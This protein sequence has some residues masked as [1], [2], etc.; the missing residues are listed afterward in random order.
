MTYV[1]C[2]AKAFRDEIIFGH[3]EAKDVAL[4]P[5]LHTTGG[6]FRNRC[7]G[8]VAQSNIQYNEVCLAVKTVQHAC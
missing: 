6:T 7:K 4:P 8:Y 1:V 3:A 5:A 2:V